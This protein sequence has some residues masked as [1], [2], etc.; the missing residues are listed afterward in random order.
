MDALSWFQQ[1]TAKPRNRWLFIL[2]FLFPVIGN[3]ISR[4]TKGRWWLVDFDAVICAAHTIRLGHSPYSLMPA[5]TG[6]QPTTFVYAPQI[7]HAFAPL[8]HAFGL[9]G[10]RWGFAILYLP[11]MMFL[12]WYAVWKP[13]AGAP[14]Q[15]RLMTLAAMVGSVISCGNIGLVMHAMAILAAFQIKRSRLP[16]IAVV[17]LGG[18]IKP[19]FMTYLVVLLLEHRPI[20]ARLRSF[21]LAA[22][23]G[24]AAMVAL[25]LTAGPFGSD[26]HRTLDTIIH[27][28]PGIGFFAA[29]TALGLDNGSV[30]TLAGFGLFAVLMASGALVLAEWS[31]LTTD[32]RIFFGLGAAQLLNPRLMDYDIFA[33]APFAAML[34][35]AAKPLGARVFAAVSWIVSGTAG[36]CVITNILEI[37]AFYRAPVTICV[38]SLLM[39]SIAGLTIWTKR[40][41]ICAWFRNP[42]PIWQDILAQ[43]L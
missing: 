8:E 33:L 24:I 12:V 2:F 39:L 23:A 37:R 19:T 11:V 28:Q 15:L 16:F 1:F 5:C 36:L 38:Y 32:E 43:R 35:M 42:L 41:R 13:M 26:W 21:A 31:G 29:T 9:M 25:L 3:V 6:I 30:V 34:V 27:Q 22:I 20:V 7:A 18:L 17:I 10:A 40:E 4:L 14:W